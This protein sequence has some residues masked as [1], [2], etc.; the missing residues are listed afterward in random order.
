MVHNPEPELYI[1]FEWLLY[2][3]CDG[4]TSVI[5]TPVAASGPRLVATRMYSMICTGSG[6][7]VVTNL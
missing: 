3:T 2:C 1:P 7:L 6:V 5:F 4:S